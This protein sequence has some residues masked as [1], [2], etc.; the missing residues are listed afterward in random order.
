M[1]N[2]IIGE[3]GTGKTKKLIDRVHQAEEKT[4]GSVV[5]INKGDRHVFDVT[6]RV[7]LVNTDEFN[8]NTY[9][10]LYGMVCGMISQNY[11]IKHIFIDSVTKIAE[12]DELLEQ[13]LDEVNAVTDKLGIEVVVVISMDEAAAP[14]GVKKYVK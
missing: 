6:H 1:L 14:A 2:V 11:D 9:N 12:G 8:V 5:L 3:K 13:F 10:S 7:R 4:D